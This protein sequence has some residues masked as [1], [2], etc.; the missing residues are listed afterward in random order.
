[1]R[2]TQ[3]PQSKI[4]EILPKCRYNSKLR[5]QPRMLTAP[6]PRFLKSKRYPTVAYRPRESCMVEGKEIRRP[7]DMAGLVKL[8]EHD[9]DTWTKLESQDASEIDSKPKA[10]RID[11]TGN[12]TSLLSSEKTEAS[13]RQGTS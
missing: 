7:C 12:M 4:M 2:E 9:T 8:E 11:E 5:L 10:G 1:M 3:Y 6:E 13:G